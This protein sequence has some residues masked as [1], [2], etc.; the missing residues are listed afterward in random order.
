MDIKTRHLNYID[1]GKCFCLFYTFLIH[2][3]YSELNAAITFCMPFFFFIAG[4]N[5]DPDK[6]SLRESA[7]LRFKQLIVPYWLLIIFYSILDKIRFRIFDTGFPLF[8]RGTISNL[9]Y[10]SFILPHVPSNFINPSNCHLWFLPAMFSASMIFA[11]LAQVF[12]KEFSVLKFISI[13]FVLLCL[14][15][16]EVKFHCL[17]QLPWGLGRGFYGAAIMLSGFCFRRFVPSDIL[18]LKK[19]PLIFALLAV[20]YLLTIPL[21]SSGAFIISSNYGDHGVI[22]L[23]ISFIGGTCGAAVLLMLMKKIDDMRNGREIKLLCDFGRKMLWIYGLQFFFFFLIELLYFKLGGKLQP[24]RF[25]MD[26]I[27]NRGI[28]IIVDLLQIAAAFFGG[29]Y[30][31]KLWDRYKK[32]FIH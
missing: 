10:G 2:T 19:R 11:L 3:G 4:W 29:S 31:A 12:K 26:M 30:A 27:P 15:S 21:H 20:V 7:R 8:W 9:L 24:D 28:Y 6:R 14:S 22:S 25:Y 23:F 16:L 1:Y 13:I 17:Y 32:R 18:D 5:H